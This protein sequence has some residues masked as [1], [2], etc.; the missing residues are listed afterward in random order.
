MQHLDGTVGSSSCPSNREG[1]GDSLGG[2]GLSFLLFLHQPRLQK[3][4]DCHPER[5][6]VS[7]KA[8]H[9]AESKD[10]VFARPITD[11]NRN[12]H[13]ALRGFDGPCLLSQGF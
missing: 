13:F 5:S 3:Q 9:L 11:S 2:S 8:I 12:S 4:K 1:L 6:K 10:P 7:R